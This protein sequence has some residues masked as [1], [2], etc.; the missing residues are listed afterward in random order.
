MDTVPIERLPLATDSGSKPGNPGFTAARVAVVIP[1]FRTRDEILG[2]LARIPAFVERIYV[3]DDCCP[4]QTGQFVEQAAAD[5]RVVVLR[6]PQNRGVGGAVKTGY[7]QALSDGLSWVVKI[8][9]DGQMD[10]ALLPQFLR[11]LVEGRADY[12]KGNRF[13]D[14]RSLA[15]MPLLRV[16][17]NAGLS[18]INKVSSG[19]WRIMDPTN[20]YTAISSA[21]LARLP[22]SKIAE[23]FFFES[24]M[25]YQAGLFNARIAEVP[26]KANY[27]GEKSNLRVARVLLQFPF[28]YLNRTAKRIFYQY[29]LR[30]FNIGSIELLLSMV[31]LPFGV[32]FGVWAWYES[33]ATGK[34]ATTGTV[35]LSVLPI[36]IGFQ[37]LLGFLH[38]DM[39]YRQGQAGSQGG[40]A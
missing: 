6:H 36:I 10:P 11:P 30:D 3:V 28:L 33:Y 39:V 29:F 23:R 5:P 13:F 22:L 26:M 8:D 15:G 17:G 2:V 31:L 14:P 20:G 4:Q 35:M 21:L 34:V 1:C 37:S 9:G 32:A 24:D 25:L 16:L 7:A 27:G 18:F 40:V 38:L 12:A 19:Y